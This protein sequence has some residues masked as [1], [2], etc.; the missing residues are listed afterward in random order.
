MTININNLIGDLSTRS[1]RAILSQLGIRSEVLR[2]H[3]TTLYARRPGAP[4]ALLA[5]PVLEAAFGWK[6]ADR[7]MA[8]LARDGFLHDELVAA[9]DRPRPKQSSEYAFPRHRRPYQ[10]QLECWRWLLDDGT[11]RSV[12]VSS[13]TGS[14]KTECFLVPILEDLV[15]QRSLNGHLSGVQALFLYPLNAL[16]NSQR[17]RLRAWCGGF[18]QDVRF[19]LYNGETPEHAKAAD[20]SQAGA[21]QIS[22]QQL[23]ADPPPVLV[24]NATMLEYMLVRTED[25]P[26]VERSQGQLRWI[27]L[28]EAHTYIGSHAAEM[29][30]LLRRVLHRF[31][32]V[33]AD[34]RFV[35]TS[36]TIGDEGAKQDLKRF[37]ADLSGAPTE[38]VHVVTGER[39]VPP[40]PAATGPPPSISTLRSMASAERFT[41]LCNHPGARALRQGL[42]QRAE[43]LAA[44][45]QTAGASE[46]TASLLGLSS[47]VVRGERTEEAFL[48]LR[49]HLFHRTQRGLWA[50]VNRNCS[51]VENTA[52]RSWGFGALFTERRTHCQHC[53]AAVFDLVVCADCGQHYLQAAENFC[54]TNNRSVL[55]QCAEDPNIDEFRLD[56]ETEH[57][58]LEVEEPSALTTHVALRLLCGKD[59]DANRTEEA[60]LEPTGQLAQKGDVGR[61]EAQFVQ[62]TPFTG[63]ALTCLR[64][65]STDNKVRSLFRE[66][67]VGAPFALST[68]VPT[69]L[70]HTPAMARGQDLP[71]QGRRILGF[72]DSRQ[73]TARLAVRLQQD[74]ERNRVR[75]VLYHALAEARPSLDE[76]AA[77]E[78]K[79]EIEALRQTNNAVLRPLLEKAEAELA[80][81]SASVGILS[82]QDAERRLASDFG[83][84]CMLKYH[85]HITRAGTSLEDYANFC[86]YR[87]FFRR[88]KRMNSA[89][90]MGLIALRYP[91]I[92][93]ASKPPGWPL[94]QTDWVSF[95]KLALD[96][97]MR[98]TS[99]VDLPE[100]YLRWMG[101]PVRQRYVQGPGFGDKPTK[102]QRRWPSVSLGVA[103]RSRL[104]RLLIVAAELDESEDSLD[105]V[106]EALECA[107]ACLRGLFLQVADGYLLNLKKAELMELAEAEVC[108]YT[109]R[110]LDTTLCGL[111]PYLP[112]R[113]PPEKCRSVALPRLPKPYWR[114]AS[115]ASVAKE[116]IN[117]WV[118]QDPKV[119]TVRTLGVWSD[120]NDRVA[121]FSPYFE[122]AE[123]SAQLD[124]LRL[125]DLEGRFRKG[126]V[127]VLSCSTTMEMGV[128]IGGLS[129]VVM[130]NAPPSAANYLQRAGR[131]GRRGEGV[132]FAITLCP[133]SPHG[134]DVFNHP[135]WPFRSAVAVPR[136]ALDSARLVQRHVNS[137]CLAWFLATLNAHR[138]KAGWFFIADDGCS[139]PADEFVGW[140]KDAGSL[141]ER[142]VRGL[143]ALVGGTALD[144]VPMQ[145]LLLRCREAMV[146]AVAQWRLEIES[147]DAEAAQFRVGPGGALAPA[148][149]AIDRQLKRLKDEYLLRELVNRQFLPGHGFPTGVVSF[150]PTTLE[151]L[152]KNLGQAGSSEGAFARR[153]GYPS[154]QLEM[155]IREYAPGGEVVI[156]GRVYE[157]GGLTLN[158][159]LRPDVAAEGVREVQAIRNAW[160]CRACGATGDAPSLLEACPSCEGRVES[161]EYLEPAGFA[162]DIRQKPHNNVTSPTFVPVEAPWISCPTPDWKTFAHPMLGRFRYSDAGHLFHGS[163]GVAGFGYAV[164]LRC[165]RAASEE[166][167][168]DE[169][170]PPQ[171]FRE[172]HARLRGAKAKDGSSTCD[173]EGFSIKRGLALGGSRTTDVF[174]L[175]L[176]ELAEQHV[177][178]AVGIALR[179]SFTRRLGIEAQEVGVAVRPSKDV[180][181][182]QLQSIF[183]FDTAEGGSGYVEAMRRHGRA[184]L[185]EAR[186]VL[187]CVNGCDAACHGCLLTYGTQYA[188]DA[189]NRHDALAFLTPERL[190]VA[191]DC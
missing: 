87:E 152:K 126:Q 127:N 146:A 134:Q 57:D 119:R 45:R 39:F 92:E 168:H 110:I 59:I 23:R 143:R 189:L 37:L 174:E 171:V 95:L 148:V 102:R 66:L 123:H 133:S 67:R 175:Q 97:F 112:E 179:Q 21:E 18:G 140:C 47:T 29:T 103:R 167:P 113:A 19:C 16:I 166:G 15:R 80:S 54:A 157:S 142:L 105:R 85:Q 94:S 128:D 63:Y 26:V 129:A 22:R 116:E 154:R 107:W 141:N 75:S 96:F 132:S 101:I 56:V 109:G 55:Q 150:I 61:A 33:P 31:G 49:V 10:H 184:A 156:D 153:S 1:A 4:G 125:R 50:C 74:A 176:A 165:G 82:W 58:E 34:V 83:V 93:A 48:P 42:A 32:A 71:S 27:V 98:D 147:L 17:D 79:R 178:W 114:E 145:Q 172:P 177:A 70:E 91:A 60:H 106:N 136:V 76:K 158:W 164:C 12:L 9:L 53:D 7:T 20:A 69:A 187:N 180:N 151:D 36:A 84:R 8:E 6:A 185:H 108:P 149:L 104:P 41:A 181:G 46:E 170:K 43:T 182:K 137:L 24:T 68:I 191:A 118:E 40:L 86:M 89:E 65:G 11:P 90:T 52:L 78:K 163:R 124:G 88:P 25:A 5:E 139:A 120:L 130:N 144:G 13:G 44:L 155:A 131:A 115:G 62:L 169:S 2:D 64:C 162:V 3:L 138:L 28:D 117:T 100:D 122:A 14:G 72:S 173:G 186:D 159:H 160:R 99:A 183:L 190:A 73:G 81:M 77:T 38:R 51:G 121:A 161:H 35:A 135:L 30:L 188:S 111:S